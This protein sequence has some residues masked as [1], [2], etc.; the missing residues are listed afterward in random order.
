MKSLFPRSALSAGSARALM[1]VASLVTI[2]CGE[3][4]SG[5][6]PVDE[7]AAVAGTYTLMSLNQQTLP[8]KLFEDATERVDVTSATLVMR[9]NRTFTETLDSQVRLNGGQPQGDQQVHNGTFT[10]SGATATFTVPAA[11]G[12]PPF[13]FSGTITGKVLVYT[14]D[15]AT[16]RYERP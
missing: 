7:Y 16:Y 9:G 13:G 1:I 14:D 4:S 3:S 8:A 11:N 10:L 2:G 15:L 5:P 6:Q 12:F